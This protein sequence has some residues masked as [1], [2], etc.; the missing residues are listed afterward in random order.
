MRRLIV[1]AFVF[2]YLWQISAMAALLLVSGFC[3]GS[4]TAF[5]HLSRRQVRKLAASA[6]P[7]ER[8]TASLLNNPNRFLTAL[9][10]ANM[11]VNVLYFSVSS[12]LSIQIAQ[13][14]GV[15]AGTLTAFVCFLAVLLIGEMLP[16]SLAYT[17]ARRFCL[18]ASPACFVLLRTLSP[19]LGFLD[20]VIVQPAVRLLV[21]PAA[22]S[23]PVS[24]E[25]IKLLLDG[26]RR[27]GLIG[28]D[29]N[30]LLSEIL[31]FGFLKVRHIMQPRVEMPACPLTMNASQ[32]RTVMHQH[33]LVKIPV[34]KQSIDA[35]AGV[36]SLRDLLLT[37]DPDP[38]ELVQPVAYVPEQK[39][40]ESLIE[41]FRD[42]GRD[43]AIVVDEYG[44]IA[45]WVRFEHIIEQL[46]RPMEE[47]SA[48]PPIEKIE[49]LSY[50]LAADLSIYDWKDAFG[51]DLEETHLTTI[52]GFVTALLGRIPQPGDQARLKNLKFTV[53]RVHSNRIQTVI[54]TLEPILEKKATDAGGTV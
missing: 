41:F 6:A 5:F 24:A 28:E 4:E 37:A 8:L 25:Q 45:G 15:M 9:L 34:Y 53:E 29:E 27:K 30:L 14:I 18:F 32:M 16:K 11:T 48:Q 3:S 47:G 10:F 51:I 21:H 33:G 26:T 44:G 20:H 36:V 49:P 1:A 7:I 43:M 52:G 46:L 22:R 13:S 42:G 54:V 39:S 2:H 31:K 17:N 23:S 50:R 19:L 38:S 12:M 35:I 40:V